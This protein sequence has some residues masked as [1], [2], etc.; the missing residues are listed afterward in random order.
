ML[1]SCAKIVT[2]TSTIHKHTYQKT[3]AKLVEWTRSTTAIRHNMWIRVLYCMYGCKQNESKTY[4]E[5][6]FLAGACVLIYPFHV[7]V[8][9]LLVSYN[10]TF[11]FIYIVGVELCIVY[12]PATIA[13]A[14]YGLL[15]KNWKCWEIAQPNYEPARTKNSNNSFWWQLLAF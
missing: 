10:L 4:E 12:I 1:L 8:F 15:V 3:C 7:F 9:I 5:N 13:I 14:F 6:E 11:S 2:D